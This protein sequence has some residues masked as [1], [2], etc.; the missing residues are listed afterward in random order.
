MNYLAI[1]ASVLALAYCTWALYD[2]KRTYR[3]IRDSWVAWWV[4]KGCPAEFA[5]L[6]TDQE[7]EKADL[8]SK[9]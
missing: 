2:T 1:A 9:E 3:K 6:F 4:E 7:K 8:L 5:D